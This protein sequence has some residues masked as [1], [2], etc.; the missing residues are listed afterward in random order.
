M[1]EMADAYEEG[2][3]R[4][5]DMVR[6]ASQEQLDKKV[7]ACPDWSVKDLFAH[8][9]GIGEDTAGMNVDAAGSSEWTQSQVE[10]RGDKSVKEIDDEW[11]QLAPK[12]AGVM[13]AIPQGRASAL[14]GDLVTH[15]LDMLGALGAKGGPGEQA[16]LVALERYVKYFGKRVKDAGLPPVTI[17]TDDG[18]SWVAGKGEPGITLTGSKIDLLRTLTGRRTQQEIKQLN[19]SGDPTPYMSLI[20]NYGMPQVPLQEWTEQPPE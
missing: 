8:L 16:L 7:P 11:E 5:R 17:Q 13:D 15:E 4:V 2:R 9:V 18:H 19:W 20:S 3:K 14:I 6:A 12:I 10:R 1:G